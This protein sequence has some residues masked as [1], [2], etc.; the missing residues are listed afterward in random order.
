MST[1]MSQ[2]ILE[3]VTMA[4]DKFINVKNYEVNC[5]CNAIS[6]PIPSTIALHLLYCRYHLTCL[7]AAT[8]VIYK[9]VH[10]CSLAGCSAVDKALSR[11]EVWSKLA[12][13]NWRGVWF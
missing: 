13:C 12:L 1:E 2:E 3:L 11:Q 10:L 8:P 5:V 4:V 6:Y 9:N 7:T